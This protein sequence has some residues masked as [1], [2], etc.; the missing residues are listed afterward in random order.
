MTLYAWKD[1]F[2]TGVDHIDGQHKQFFYLLNEMAIA[3]DQR[4]EKEILDLLLADLDRYARIHFS[5]E[6]KLMEGI[7]YPDLPRHRQEHEYFVGQLATLHQRHDRG[8]ERVGSSAL[9]F[10]RDWFMNHI[11][12]EDLKWAERLFGGRPP[13]LQ[14][15]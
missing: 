13:L 5:T 11:L 3:I 9:E 10:M 4:R 12:A 7:G 8:D 1:A 2:R 14:V 15:R 6:E